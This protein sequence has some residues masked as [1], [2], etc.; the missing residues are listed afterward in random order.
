MP[1]A[2]SPHLT[3]PR[4]GS[5]TAAL[6]LALASATACSGG[7]GPSET[8]TAPAATPAPTATEAA[9]T[10]PPST[11]A[12]TDPE[13]TATATATPTAT[14]TAAPTA[15]EG[16]PSP[17]PG[18]ETPTPTA[19]PTGTPTIPPVAVPL[20]GFGIITG[21]CGVLDPADLESAAPRLIENAIDFG[22]EVYS[23]DVLSEDGQVLY[24][25]P[26]AGGSS[27]DSEVI[28]FEILYR[29]ELADLLKTETQI[30]Y[31]A[32]G[33]LTDIL[34]EIDGEK[35]GVSVTRAVTGPGQTYTLADA[36]RV[37]TK[38]LEGI[39]ESTDHVSEGDRWVKQILH[40][41]AVD[42]AAA[43]TMA[44]AWALADVELVGDT[45]GIITA[46]AG[47]DAFLY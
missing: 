9:S 6:L 13:A 44:E 42:D 25:T 8:P 26:N 41:I 17:S 43:A 38:K 3:D 34:V 27:S 4:T 28:S 20:A 15:T 12:P 36:Q 33:S 32:Q 1:R 47:E 18:A 23:E 35:V 45:I 46:T 22:E 21:P 31:D 39:Q 37:L 2:A 29:C 5:L 30:D 19:A 14:S 16:A 11:P 7:E 40:V 24:N 10:A